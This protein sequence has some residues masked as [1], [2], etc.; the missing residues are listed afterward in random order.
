MLRWRN[1]RPLRVLDFDLENRPLAYLGFDYTTAEVTAIAASWEGSDRV[2]VKLLGRNTSEE[3][4]GGFVALYDQADMVTGH[5]V[6]K[7]DLPVL[8]G[9]LLELGMPPLKQKL[10]SDTKM[11]LADSRYL[12]LSQESLAAMFG[13][14]HRKE[15]M[16]QTQW[17]D[18]NRLTAKGLR[19]TRRRVAGDVRQHKELRRKLIQ[20]GVLGPPRLWRP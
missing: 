14:S 18:A 8:N 19:E 2:W 7:H 5:Y 20:V 16:N 9:A 12:S 3:M 11:D 6:R 4:L 17:R 15:H 1:G 13:L 10:V